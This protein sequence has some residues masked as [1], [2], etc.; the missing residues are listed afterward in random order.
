MEKFA[1]EADLPSQTVYAWQNGR[2]DSSLNSMINISEVLGRTV[3]DL[4]VEV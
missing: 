2:W 3:G 1:E 4:F